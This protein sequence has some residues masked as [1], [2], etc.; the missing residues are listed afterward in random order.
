MWSISGIK[1]WEILPRLL[2]EKMAVNPSKY[3]G[4]N[5]ISTWKEI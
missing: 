2:D 5:G 3:R 1:V 4:F